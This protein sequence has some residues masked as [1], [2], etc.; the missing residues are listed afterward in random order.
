[1]NLFTIFDDLSDSALSEF[2]KYNTES[3]DNIK[4]YAVTVHEKNL[5]EAEATTLFYAFKLLDLNICEGK[6]HIFNE[7]FKTPLENIEL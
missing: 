3:T 2:Y 7:L 4:H 6:S 5:T 1:M